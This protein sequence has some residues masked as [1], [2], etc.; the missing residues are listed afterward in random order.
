MS[1]TTLTIRDTDAFRTAHRLMDGRI[2]FLG[3]QAKGHVACLLQG[4]DGLYQDRRAGCV[5][6]L[7][8]NLPLLGKREPSYKEELSFQGQD[9]LGQ[10]PWFP[11]DKESLTHLGVKVPGKAARRGALGIDV[12]TVGIGASVPEDLD[13]YSQELLIAIR[14]AGDV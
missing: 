11:S 4:Q 8:K 13:L 6:F 7:L 9:L 1:L 2:L 10:A 5:E 14:K 12:A 3:G